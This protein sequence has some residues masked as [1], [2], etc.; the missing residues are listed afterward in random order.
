M[1]RCSCFFFLF[2]FTMWNKELLFLWCRVNLNSSSVSLY[3]ITGVTL[4]ITG[5]TLPL[6]MAHFHDHSLFWVS[7]S[8]DPPFPRPCPPANFWQVPKKE[9]NQARFIPRQ[10]TLKPQPQKNNSNQTPFVITY[11]PALPNVSTAV[12]KNINIPQSSNRCKLISNF[13]F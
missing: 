13:C 6:L 2:S 1:F 5:I 10:E 11:N 4:R 12:R 3:R 7:K 8:C 9:I